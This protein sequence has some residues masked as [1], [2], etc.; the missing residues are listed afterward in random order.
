[1]RRKAK[2]RELERSAER[3]RLDEEMRPFR[4]A[5]REEN[6]TN[7]LLRAVRQALRVSAV[8]IGENAGVSRDAVFDFERRELESSITLRSMSKLADA[9]DCKMV[10]GIVPKG[11]QT[12]EELVEERLWRSVLENSGQ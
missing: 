4:R 9:M 1:M 8:E 5:G 7:G 6:P 11:G 10:Y 2:K 12:L 3:K